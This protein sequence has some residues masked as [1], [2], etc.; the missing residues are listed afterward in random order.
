MNARA[1]VKPFWPANAEYQAAAV[2]DHALT[3]NGEDFN[4]RRSEL[5]AECFERAEAI[6][7]DHFTLSADDFVRKYG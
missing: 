5:F 4:R 6:R 3:E 2:L 7:A 1:I